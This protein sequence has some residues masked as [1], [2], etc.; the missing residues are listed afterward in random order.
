MTFKF[1]V[2]HS[3]L[4]IIIETDSLEPVTGVQN[5]KR[6]L[7]FVGLEEDLTLSN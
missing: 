1:T 3:D 7:R 4:R 5:I 2:D 6:D